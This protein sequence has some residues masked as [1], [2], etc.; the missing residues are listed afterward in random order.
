MWEGHWEVFLALEMQ[1]RNRSRIEHF[2][3]ATRGRVAIMI[4]GIGSRACS[5][6]FA[7]IFIQ[8]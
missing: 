7:W 3:D 2:E 5:E 1:L 4:H 6:S 8:P